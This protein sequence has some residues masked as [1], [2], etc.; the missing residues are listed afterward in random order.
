[1][2]EEKQKEKMHPPLRTLLIMIGIFAIIALLLFFMRAD[3]LKK[4]NEKLEALQKGQFLIAH[5]AHL[6]SKEKNS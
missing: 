6:P 3:I 5:T 2:P 1:M 4:V